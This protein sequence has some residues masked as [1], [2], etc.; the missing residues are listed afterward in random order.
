MSKE[1]IKYTFQALGSR[2]EIVLD[3]LH[4]DLAEDCFLLAKGEVDRIEKKF[5]RYREDSVVSLINAAAGK[6]SIECD[7]ET[8][9]LIRFGQSLYKVSGGLFDMTAGALSKAWD[10]RSGTIPSDAE[11][12]FF[13]GLVGWPKV[14]WD[15]RHIRLPSTGMQ[16]DFGGFGKEYAV[17]RVSTLLR[18]RGVK[19][20]YV[21]FGGDIAVMGPKADQSP[22]LL[23]I[24]DPRKSGQ[25]VATIPVFIGALASSG[26]YE[27]FFEKD[28]KR[29]CHVIHPRTGHPVNYWRSISVLA[30]QVV[31]A[32]GYST[33]AMLMECEGLNF[34]QSSGLEFLAIDQQGAVH[35]N[36]VKST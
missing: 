7:A 28:G 19:A 14:E 31:I 35:R 13:R 32:G 17:D 24:Q 8:C 6:S 26:D 2:C 29:Y 21:N 3:E 9:D 12:D 30:S 15:G 4:A 25:V 34:L 5:S 18:A 20:G 33:V 22:W 1:V 16:I 36:E 27:R 11:L 23:G 10:F